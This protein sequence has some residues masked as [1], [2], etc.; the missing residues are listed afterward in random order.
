MRQSGLPQ[1][2]RDRLKSLCASFSPGM[3][4]GELAVLDGGGRTADAVA[5]EPSVVRALSTTALH[6]IERETPT[7]AAQLYRNLSLHLA[8]RLREA[9]RAWQR[10]AG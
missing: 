4:F 7:I 5:D 9:S 10:A 8:V 3:T 6:Q 1:A 2:S